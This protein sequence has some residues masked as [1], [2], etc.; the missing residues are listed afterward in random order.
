MYKIHHAYIQNICDEP[1]AW[2]REVPR[3]DLD[4]HTHTHTHEHTYIHT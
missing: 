3:A 4:Q 1:A 2:V